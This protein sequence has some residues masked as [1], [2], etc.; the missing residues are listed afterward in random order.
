MITK[1]RL[2]A[3]LL[4]YDKREMSLTAPDIGKYSGIE[5]GL[6]VRAMAYTLCTAYDDKR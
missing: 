2:R 6:P 1:S 4:D 3:Y 5:D